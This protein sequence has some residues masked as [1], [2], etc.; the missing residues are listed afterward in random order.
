MQRQKGFWPVTGSWKRVGHTTFTDLGLHMAGKSSAFAASGR[1]ERVSLI[2]TGRCTQ[3]LLFQTD[4]EPLDFVI[5]EKWQRGR[6][7]CCERAYRLPAHTQHITSN[8]LLLGEIST[9]SPSNSELSTLQKTHTQTSFLTETKTSFEMHL[10]RK[11]WQWEDML[12]TRF[13]EAL[14]SDFICS[15]PDNK[16]EN[17][18]EKKRES[19][20]HLMCSQT[21]WLQWQKN[22]DDAADNWYNTVSGSPH[23]FGP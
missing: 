22:R 2:Q 10:V 7:A 19:N 15:P 3:V 5:E 12:D 1:D 17:T 8:F 13:L 20:S 6:P 23:A 4:Q 21:C 18:R 14:L 11:Q 9:I 16:R